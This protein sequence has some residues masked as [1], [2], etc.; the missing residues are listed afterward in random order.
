MCVSLYRL[1]VKKYAFIVTY[2]VLFQIRTFVANKRFLTQIFT[3]KKTDLIWAKKWPLKPLVRILRTLGTATSQYR[4]YWVKF[5]S[6]PF[7]GKKRPSLIESNAP[8]WRLFALYAIAHCTSEQDY[9]APSC[10]G[11]NTPLQLFLD[12]FSK[13]FHFLFKCAWLTG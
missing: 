5:S 9:G 10:N 8:Y 6:Q 13:D 11:V 1:Q 2:H 12:I 4:I 7:Q 3:E